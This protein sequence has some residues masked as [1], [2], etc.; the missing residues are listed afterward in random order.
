MSGAH[1]SAAVRR[2]FARAA[3]RYDRAAT[4]QR[5][6]GRRLFE[7]LDD[8]TLAP[9]RILDLGAGTGREARRLRRRWPDAQV[10]EVDFA[11]AM[12]ARRPWW[13]P[14][15]TAVCADAAALPF[16][17][18]SVDLVYS[19]LMLQ[20][21]PEPERVF[22]ELRRV[23]RP[24]GWLV[25]STLGPASL[26]ELRAAWAEVDPD[27]AHVNRFPPPERLGAALLA[28]GFVEPV[29]D[30]DR[31]RFG[32]R[33]FEAMLASLRELGANTVAGRGRGLTGKRRW[34][35]LRAACA[36]RRDPAG[37]WRLSYEA[38]YLVARRHPGHAPL[39]DRRGDRQA[40]GGR[41]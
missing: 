7:H 37:R 29:L 1:W 20:W 31:L 16:A 39:R 13:A 12:L 27:G 33:S 2:A 34:A 38:V 15:R 28:A 41:L 40:G 32:Y 11:W 9:R 21:C 24:G 22:A 35:A 6:I 5:S 14:A 8:L 18:A 30:C 3:A 25:A 26:A 10:V 19:N 4:V 17:D 23:L 36:R